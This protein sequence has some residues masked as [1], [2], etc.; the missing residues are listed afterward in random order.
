MVL[1]VL[2]LGSYGQAGAGKRG[3]ACLSLRVKTKQR[4]EGDAMKFAN[5][6]RAAAWVSILLGRRQPSAIEMG[7]QPSNPNYLYVGTAEPDAERLAA[8]NTATVRHHSSDSIGTLHELIDVV[9]PVAVVV[10]PDGSLDVYGYVGVVDQRT[11]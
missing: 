1:G 7:R 6:D 8:R 9:E 11:H 4:S 2:Y 5:E 10:R 3:N